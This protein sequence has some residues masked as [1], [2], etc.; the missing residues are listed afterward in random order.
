MKLSRGSLGVWVAP[1]AGVPMPGV[2]YQ[3]RD[4]PACFIPVGRPVL[5]AQAQ[6]LAIRPGVF[7]ERHVGFFL[8]L[9]LDRCGELGP[10]QVAG[11]TIPQRLRFA[12]YL[13]MKVGGLRRCLARIL[14][15]QSGR[16][17]RWNH[18][19]RGREPSRTG[20]PWLLD[21]KDIAVFPG[22]PAAKEFLARQQTTNTR[23]G[24]DPSE[25]LADALRKR[26]ADRWVEALELLEEADA[27]FR[28]RSWSRETPLRFDIFLELARTEMQLGPPGLMPHTSTNI[29]RSLSGQRLGTPTADLVR[30]RA[31]Y[32]AALVCSQRDDRAARADALTHVERARELLK[33]RVD[34]AGVREYWRVCAE[35]ELSLA[36]LTGAIPPKR[37]S[38][39]LQASR[40]L[41][42]ST[43]QKRMSYGE[44]LIHANRPAEAID[45]IR[46]AID[47]RRLSQPAWVIA[48]RLD[49]TA[50]WQTGAKTNRTIETLERVEEKA[51]SLGF[52][53]QARVIQRTKKRVRRGV[54]S[55]P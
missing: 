46:P 22:S 26:K 42:E 40:V 41:E 32:I 31:H 34:P 48:E 16:I 51:E 8:L 5:P 19:V 23:R 30:A 13:G 52:A 1:M 29:M 6:D 4:V 28:R 55:N 35:H 9:V 45:Y 12:E 54:R 7:T 36:R 24:S 15:P 53:H 10:T 18:T 49:A 44:S 17:L 37:S 33:G 11:K 39:I 3:L 47:S 20:G 38:A 2:G 27:M 50:R 14:A 21:V 25:L 43:E